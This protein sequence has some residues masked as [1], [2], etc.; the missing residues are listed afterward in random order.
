MAAADVT[1]STAENLVYVSMNGH[2]PNACMI[3]PFGTLEKPEDLFPA[4]SYRNLEL[5]LTGEASAG[6][7]RVVTQQLRI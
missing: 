2:A 7:V 3:I 5:Q 4:P 1:L 6:A